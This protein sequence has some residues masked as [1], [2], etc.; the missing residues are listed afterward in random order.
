[1]IAMQDLQS[2]Q[3]VE[4]AF[5]DGSST[6]LTIVR[7]GDSSAPVVLCLPAMGVRSGYYELL[8]D[9]LADEGFTAVLADLRGSGSSSVRA[10]RRVSFGYSDILELEL[11]GIVDA[12]CREL[13]VDQVVVLG[14]S[15][16]GQLGLM[17]AAT[18]T[19]VSRV[20]LVA[21]GSAWYRKVPGL[22]SVGRFLGLQLLFGTTLLWGHLPEW[23]P[24]A[25]REARRLVLD[26][27]HESMTGRYRVT[28]SDVDYE[29]ALAESTV[30]ALFVIFPGDGFV[31]RPNV[32]HLAAK[33]RTAAVAWRE[34]P[35]AEFGLSRSHHF[36]W[37][38][39]PQAVAAAVAGWV[40]RSSTDATVG[41]R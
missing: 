35:P 29:K 36:R 32:E 21:S 25:G 27:G 24:F 22:G 16:G 4:V 26:W 20:V 39:R 2:S 23:F 33:L 10:G 28:R 40:G 17:Y 37:V 3:H 12:V 30:P 18:S 9:A 6:E 34:I 7:T 14:H 11:P 13:G 31:P 8:A 5:A 41:E 38:F 15:L 1:V 19:R